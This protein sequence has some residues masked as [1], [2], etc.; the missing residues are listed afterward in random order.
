[1]R[2]SENVT[3]PLTS[4]SCRSPGQSSGVPAHPTLPN[5]PSPRA[6]PQ[7]PNPELGVGVEGLNLSLFD[8]ALPNLNL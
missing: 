2:G 8:L 7:A 6:R 1:M 4:A 5:L 3:S